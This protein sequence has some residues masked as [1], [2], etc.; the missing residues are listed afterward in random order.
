MLLFLCH[1]VQVPVVCLSNTSQCF[2]RPQAV[3][4]QTVS[5]ALKALQFPLSTTHLIGILGIEA[6]AHVSLF[7]SFVPSLDFLQ[8]L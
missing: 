1:V 5:T 6:S 8:F 3:V 4:L 7:F 2:A